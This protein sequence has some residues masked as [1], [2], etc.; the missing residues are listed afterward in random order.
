MTKTARGLTLLLSPW[1]IVPLL[2]AVVFLLYF[3]SLPGWAASDDLHQLKGALAG[4]RPFDGFFR[5]LERGV[6][7]LNVRWFGLYDLRFAHAAGLAGLLSVVVSTYALGRLLPCSALSARLPMALPAYLSTGLAPALAAAFVAVSSLAVASTVQIDTLSQQFV[8]VFAL[9]F[10]H[11]LLAAKARSS[12]P[13]YALAYGFALLAL[14]SKESAPGLVAAVPLAAL[15]FRPPARTERRGA[16]RARL[17]ELFG[18]LL[19]VALVAALYLALRIVSGVGFGDADAGQYN[20]QLT[21]ARLL[22]NLALYGGSLLYT[23]GSTLD[24]LPVLKP[25][26][27]AVSGLLT[28]VL[29][30]PSLVGAAHLVRKRL[31][32]R[33]LLGLFLLT[34]AGTFPVVLTEQVSELY[35]HG[36]LP[37]YALLLGFSFP[38]GVAAL[39]D[40]FR[41]QWLR[42]G[43]ALFITVLLVWSAAGAAEKVRL[44]DELGESSRGYFKQ[45]QAFLET[46]PA[47]PLRFCWS[48]PPTSGAFYS[49]FVMRP[50]LVVGRAMGFA[51]W[52]AGRPLYLAA[53]DRPFSNTGA[54]AGTWLPSPVPL[55]TPPPE[56]LPRTAANRCTHRVDLEGNTL[57]FTRD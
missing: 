32:R 12:W 56:S 54:V 2:A 4:V 8:T 52:L 45:A 25:G 7:L 13:L 11:A 21:P 27:V 33:P 20:L 6:N 22:Q 35:T 55:D 15:L 18:D 29:L 46:A 23:G 53:P 39:A 38:A 14:L 44:I 42:P 50:E 30:I 28:A 16:L 10:L 51:A 19:G 24:L 37:F 31:F 41:A 1:V 26:R 49:T 5:P 40:R 57:R 3:R 47:G 36:S 17:G 48:S 43:A 34:L 9:L